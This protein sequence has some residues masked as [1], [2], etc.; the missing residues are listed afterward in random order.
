MR[1]IHV[2]GLASIFLCLPSLTKAQTRLLTGLGGPLGFGNECLGQNDDG[3]SLAIDVARAFPE[4]LNFFGTVHRQLF[5]NTNGNITFA[6]PLPTY[7]PDPFP[8]A[9]RPMIAPFWADVD[10]RREM[11]GLFG[12]RSCEGPGDGEAVMGPPCDRPPENGIWWHLRDG[13]AVFTWDR[14]GYYRCRWDK[15]MTFQLILSRPSG[16]YAPGD[17]DVE[18]RYTRCEWET[19]DAS[20]GKG[21]F[22]G[23][24]AQA[25]FDAGNRRDYVMIEGSRMDGIARR[26]CTMS[27]VGI[28]GTWRF[29]IRNGRVICPDAGAPCT[30]PGRVGLCAQGVTQCVG[31]GRECVPQFEPQPERCDNLDNDCDGNVDESD[32]QP[33]CPVGEGCVRGMCVGYCLEGGCPE[34]Y[35]CRDGVECVENACLKVRCEGN[36]RCRGGRCVDACEGVICPY[37]Q[38]CRL[39]R[40]FDPCNNVRCDEGCSV[41]VEGRCTIAC[42]QMSCP[43]GQVCSS[44]GRCIEAACERVECPPGTHCEGGRCVDNCEGARCPEGEICRMG[45]CVFDPTQTPIHPDAHVEWPDAASLGA[46]TG[47]DAGSRRQNLGRQSA[48]GCE[49][50]LMRGRKPLPSLLGFLIAL[51]AFFRVAKRSFLG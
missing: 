7:T 33:L 3:S 51:L 30:I 37:G 39:G 14:V 11:R 23:T 31:M 35:T 42:T 6:G 28:P 36:Q 26:L 50:Q 45:Q 18:F 49:C 38:T 15:R 40:C 20:G 41:C 46:D 19:G 34:G 10:T 8:V 47:I 12:F 44:S 24:Q 13:L 21:G 25:G 22:G 32:G 29:Q 4:G 43:A 27:N 17:F 5:V 16:C 48:T 2:I 1:K 9:N